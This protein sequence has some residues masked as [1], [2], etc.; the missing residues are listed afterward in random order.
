MSLGIEALGVRGEWA[1]VIVQV[2]V[3]GNLS[4]SGRV[5]R[6]DQRNTGTSE[7]QDWSTV[8]GE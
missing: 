7:K 5:V 4:H 1:L 3:F 2:G 8:E 6:S